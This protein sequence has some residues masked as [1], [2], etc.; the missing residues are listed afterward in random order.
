MAENTE[1]QRSVAS[2]FGELVELNADERAQRL[3]VLEAHAPD[4]ARELRALLELDAGAG[5]FFGVH[6]I[7]ADGGYAAD[8][9]P[10]YSAGDSV[11]GR[12]R[13]VA[14]IGRGGMG[15]VWR[16]RDE[17]LDR[18]VA[19]KFLRLAED[20]TAPARRAVRSRFLLEARA[21]ASID[22]PNVASVYD[23]G[24]TREHRLYI[25]MAHCAGG[26]L[27]QRLA[28]GPLPVQTALQIA[29][30]IAAG[31]A[32]AHRRG[33]IH[34][35]IKPANVLFDAN[36]TPRLA[37]FGIALLPGANMTQSGLIVGTLQYV[38]PEQLRGDKPDERADLWA[39]GVTLY[40]MLTGRRPFVAQSQA[41]LIH[42]LLH[43]DPTPVRDRSPDTPPALGVLLDELLA[44]DPTKRPTS[45][46]AVVERLRSISRGERMPQIGA[47]VRAETGA[48]KAPEHLTPLIG[49]D[50]EIG[51]LLH[52]LDTTRLLTITGA[53]GSGKTRLAA[54]A[55]KRAAADSMP[56]TTWVDFTP[57]DAPELV[58][59]Q[60]AAA[61]RAPETGHS[62]R[63]ESAAR[64]IGDAP[65]L[66]VLDNCEHVVSA[67]AD[68]AQWLL[69]R[70]PGL[71]I[72]ATSREPLALHGEV[73]WL[74]PLLDNDDA[75]T[76]FEQRASA[77][78]PAFRLT[79]E[80]RRVVQSICARLDCI[81]LAIELAAARV[82]VLT[83]A[84]IASRLD[85]TFQLLT[86]GNRSTVPRHRTL[87]ATMDWSHELLLPRERALLRRL[88]VFSG[89]FTMDAAEVICADRPGASATV[90]EQLSTHDVLDVLSSLVEK[91][92]VTLDSDDHT[93]RYRL[94]ETVRQFGAEQLDAA[95]EVELYQA[96]H[97]EYFVHFAEA[98]E[99]KMLNHELTSRLM[100]QLV[101][102][103]DNL[104]VASAWCVQGDPHAHNRAEMALRLAGAL[105]W[106]WNASPAWTGT[107]RYG[108]LSEFV[109]RALERGVDAP[110][111]L[112]ARALHS[113][114]M[115]GLG[116]GAWDEGR[117]AQTEARLIARAIG[118]S[119]LEAWCATFLGAVLLMTG[120]VA[121]ADEAITAADAAVPSQPASMLRGMIG[122]WTAIAARA[123]GDI[124]VARQT[125]E[126]SIAIFRE[127][128]T[129]FGLAHDAALLGGVLLELGLLDSAAAHL[130]ESMEINLDL[131][132]GWGIAV[133]LEGLSALAHAR[134]DH[135]IAARL[136][137]AVDAWREKTGIVMPVFYTLN[138]DQRVTDAKAALGSAYAS[139]YASG[140]GLTPA[141]AAALTF[142]ERKASDAF[143][144]ETVIR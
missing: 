118:A 84:Q 2:L 17:R 96:A 22:H 61:L 98:L 5:D 36:E 87:R 45:S 79:P 116:T 44:K 49:R 64:V 20:D 60:I 70:C 32:E 115:L 12:Y 127:L 67:A 69:R 63:L 119:V 27:A 31:L 108:E 134:G 121:G 51:R 92:M 112:R 143:S 19:L 42:A 128:R 58:P 3:L 25:A 56:Q 82:R 40:E 90:R 83:P 107:A 135:D 133:S 131:R 85:D 47:A 16:A 136:L 14:E 78:N 24:G 37:D 124:A 88:S 113:L 99:P 52:M 18:D 106:Y 100:R 57:L 21:A 86:G 6:T 103:D 4:V 81:P 41:A 30:G 104:R 48:A 54:E 65:W 35:D 26:S 126:Q 73:S 129:P 123:R 142:E 109:R 62:S 140:R 66:L 94:L 80:N 97:A 89:G 95:G 117:R 46:A 144:V 76:L 15:T 43:T 10:S 55:A 77:V 137:G 8:H 139:T 38:A 71:R 105:F 102:D 120:D 91:S 68:A 75:C 122:S 125:L 59:L 138:R 28:Q 110:Q 72:L 23:V 130:R 74:I 53:G 93:L 50:A 1:S 132:P 11:V 9:G 13:L 29:T 101:R 7:D 111:F 33:I 39:F 141:A 114:G 34:R